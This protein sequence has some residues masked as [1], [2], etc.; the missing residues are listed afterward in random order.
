MVVGRGEHANPFI[1]ENAWVL[2][3]GNPQLRKRRI[4]DTQDFVCHEKHILG[5]ILGNDGKEKKLIPLGDWVL[6]E[7]FKGE[8]V[9][10]SGIVTKLETRNYQSLKGWPR[11]VGLMPPGRSRKVEININFES[12]PN[13]YC[14]LIG[15]QEH[16]K[17]FTYQGK[18]YLL[19]KSNDIAFEC[20]K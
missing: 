17:E 15:W 7:R 12:N 9:D 5:L 2:Y 14:Q 11:A 8:E 6:F 18:H 4:N 1:Q 16:M 13:E 20:R 19:I 10:A 3:D